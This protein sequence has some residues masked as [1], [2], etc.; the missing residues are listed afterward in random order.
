MEE[1]VL[2]KKKMGRP[3]KPTSERV[4]PVGISLSVDS[5]IKLDNYCDRTRVSRSKAIAD[6]IEKFCANNK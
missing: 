1:K 5:A 3:R 6:M 2:I 4:V